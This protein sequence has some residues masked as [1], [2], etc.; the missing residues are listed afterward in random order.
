MFG[1]PNITGGFWDLYPLRS[2]A[3]TAMGTASG[4]F[5]TGY[6]PSSGIHSCDYD[7]SYDVADGLGFEASRSNVLYSG[8]SLQPSAAQVLMIIK[9]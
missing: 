6:R 9:V 2:V 1:R 4:A 5:Y 3:E 7:Y 8:S